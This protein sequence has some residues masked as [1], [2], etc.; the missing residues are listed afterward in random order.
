MSHGM[1]GTVSP[2]SGWKNSGAAVSI[3]AT[4]ANRLQF[5]QLEWQRH[6]FLLGHE[7][8]CFNHNEWAD[9]GDSHLHSELVQVTVQT[10]PAGLA[11]S[12]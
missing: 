8:S 7:Q 6:R 4:P 3:H 5:Q 10:N 12:G 1:G 9:Y 2:A 11:F